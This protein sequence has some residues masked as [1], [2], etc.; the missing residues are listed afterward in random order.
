MAFE[1]RVTLVNDRVTRGD[2]EVVRNALVRAGVMSRGERVVD[3]LGSA[4]GVFAST[5]GLPSGV[6]EQ[7]VPLSWLD[8][9][10][11]FVA[12]RPKAIL[13]RFLA[14]VNGNSDEGDLETTFSEASTVECHV[15]VFESTIVLLVPIPF[16]IVE[17]ARALGTGVG[18]T[19]AVKDA[20]ASFESEF[21]NAPH[22]HHGWKATGS[23]P[24]R[25]ESVSAWEPRSFLLRVIPTEAVEAAY[26][27]LRHWRKESDVAKEPSLLHRLR[28]LAQRLIPDD[29]AAFDNMQGIALSRTPT[30]DQSRSGIALF[31]ETSIP[32]ENTIFFVL[33][34]RWGLLDG[35]VRL[36]IDRDKLQSPLQ[37]SLELIQLCRFPDEHRALVA[38]F[39]LRTLLNPSAS[40]PVLQQRAAGAARDLDGAHGSVESVALAFVGYQFSAFRRRLLVPLRSQQAGG[41]KRTFDVDPNDAQGTFLRDIKHV[42]IIATNN[43]VAICERELSDANYGSDER[44]RREMV[45]TMSVRGGNRVA[46]DFSSVLLISIT[47]TSTEPGDAVQHVVLRVGIVYASKPLF[48]A[49]GQPGLFAAAH[50]EASVEV[51]KFFVCGP[52][53]IEEA[54]H[55]Q[56]LWL[57]YVGKAV[58][59]DCTPDEMNATFAM[60]HGVATAKLPSGE[61]ELFAS[62]WDR[63]AGGDPVR[64]TPT[65]GSCL[66]TKRQ[67]SVCLDQ[68]VPSDVA[69][70]MVFSALLTAGHS[71]RDRALFLSSL[72]PASGTDYPRAILLTFPQFVRGITVLMSGTLRQRADALFGVLDNKCVDAFSL[73]QLH[74]LLRQVSNSVDVPNIWQLFPSHKSQWIP[75]EEWNHFVLQGQSTIQQRLRGLGLLCETTTGHWHKVVFVGHPLWRP[76]VRI[77]ITLSL[78]GSYIRAQGDRKSSDA[79]PVVDRVPNVWKDSLPWLRDAGDTIPQRTHVFVQKRYQHQRIYALDTGALID[80]VWHHELAMQ[81]RRNFCIEL[82]PEVFAGIRDNAGVRFED[83]VRTLGVGSFTSGLLGSAFLGAR[84]PSFP[85]TNARVATAFQDGAGHVRPLSHVVAGADERFLIQF[86]DAAGLHK[87]LAILPKYDV[88]LEKHHKSSILPRYLGLYVVCYP[89]EATMP[90]ERN[91]T[92]TFFAL[93]LAP[94]AK[95]AVSRGCEPFGPSDR[96]VF[97]DGHSPASVETTQSI[98]L[99]PLR[100]NVHGSS[101]DKVGSVLKR[102]IRFLA[103]ECGLTHFSIMLAFTVCETPSPAVRPQR[104]EESIQRLD[105]VTNPLSDESPHYL[106]NLSRLGRSGGV[107]KMSFNMEDDD[108]GG[109]D[110][111]F[112]DAQERRVRSLLAAKSTSRWVSPVSQKETGR[113][114]VLPTTWQCAMCGNIRARVNHAEV[115]RQE[116]RCAICSGVSEAIPSSCPDAA[117]KILVSAKNPRLARSLVHS[118]THGDSFLRLAGVTE[119]ERFAARAADVSD[120]GNVVVSAQVEGTSVAGIALFSVVDLLGVP[121]PTA[122]PPELCSKYGRTVLANV[123]ETLGDDFL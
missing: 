96:L 72:Q 4:V 71:T 37:A 31:W 66:L 45:S 106:A 5:G 65:I 79:K 105:V 117:T 90:R 92:L 108:C 91:M 73:Q 33:K 27:L 86:L 123:L 29:L 39:G 67:L 81:S 10:D 62:P 36:A 13:T 69:S 61:V 43:I 53:A 23:S 41:K 40:P 107:T 118:P 20:A 97:I 58:G 46:L 70:S 82:C 116:T 60:F 26:P 35:A 38:F 11:R 6:E 99:R 110:E 121:K 15:L 42:S 89:E 19:L 55:L 56:R 54:R 112:R 1:T 103:D 48:R 16:W 22:K 114:S 12:L 7:F 44:Y 64:V 88:F 122:E 8:S 47:E 98:Q 68:C 25:T 21:L 83:V 63:T 28:G 78:V 109:E 50:P 75:R 87:M 3:Y 102:D 59:C 100:L 85:Y 9:D 84:A 119:V 115:G 32:V 111:V 34:A 94:A 76:F 49:S 24:F 57:L 104:S 80:E 17:E 101:R 74:L 52:R 120:P 93:L 113:A 30:G 51:H 95:L 2:V 18:P 77:M 14:V